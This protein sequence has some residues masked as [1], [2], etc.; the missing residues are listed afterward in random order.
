MQQEHYGAA[1]ANI[2]EQ[3]R[4]GKKNLYV[5]EVNVFHTIKRKSDRNNPGENIMDQ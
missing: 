2:I 5:S 3:T 4:R 1:S